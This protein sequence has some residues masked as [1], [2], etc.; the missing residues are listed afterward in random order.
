MKH[1]RFVSPEFFLRQLRAQEAVAQFMFAWEREGGGVYSFSVPI[2]LGGA[3]DPAVVRFCERCVKFVLWAAGGW[4][5]YLSGPQEI[6]NAIAAA[7][8]MKGERHFDLEFI[9]I[10]YGRPLEI[11]RCGPD[12]IP[13]TRDTEHR[14]ETAMTGCR[15]GFDLGASD[16][17]I[18]AVQDGAVT[19]SEEFPWD[20][21]NAVDPEY[22]FSLL[23]EGLKKAAATLPRVDSIGG[24]TAGV[25]VA[26]RLKTASLF[27]SIPQEKKSDA[28]N[29]FLRLEE[30]WRVPVEVANDGDVTALSAYLS[31]GLTGVLGVAM[32]SS[33]A[34]GFLD[35]TG[36][37]TGRLNEL[38]FCPVDFACNAPA[39]EWSGDTGV[40]AMYF[41]QQA[42]NRL[43]QHYE[44]NIP[45]TLSLPE[46]LVEVQNRMKATPNAILPIYETI[47]EHLGHS[48]VWY[49]EFYDY[50]HLLVLG[51]VTTGQGGDVI[52]ETARRVIQ[53]DFPD[54]VDAIKLSMPDEK[55]K[56]LGQAVAAAALVRK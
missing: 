30:A 12:A 34:G 33:Q 3:T 39:D 56:R 45:P 40:G 31:S 32:G 38:A 9:E 28:E 44:L 52:L 53:K 6:C 2:P 18:S 15:I 27:R 25:V 1:P 24:S 54:R 48:A 29:I 21:K 51:R 41:S 26:N 11:V 17:K 43:I 55:N 14:V 20:P 13:Q 50:E 10:V 4:K 5:L 35:R 22:H 36:A 47:G 23:N 7:Y 42:V 8:S 37:L 16:F 19:F 46:K 49:R